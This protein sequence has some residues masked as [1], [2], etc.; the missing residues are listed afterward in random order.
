M[1]RIGFFLKVWLWDFAEAWFVSLPWRR[2]AGGL[3]FLLV[4]GF[5]LASTLVIGSGEKGLRGY[6]LRSQ[7][8]EALASD[9]WETAR[10]VLNRQLQNSPEDRDAK[11]QMARVLEA[12]GEREPAEHIMRSLTFV[13][14]PADERS[15]KPNGAPEEFDD[16]REWRRFGGADPRAARWMVQHVYRPQP[17]DEM[18]QVDRRDFLGLLKWMYESSP[19]DVPLRRLYAEKLLEARM[20]REALPVLVTLIQEGPGIGL[21]AATIARFL[22]DQRGAA[23]YAEQSLQQFAA[24]IPQEPTN[25]SLAVALARCQVFLGR[26]SA[27]VHTIQAAIKRSEQDEDRRLLGQILAEALVTWADAL[28]GKADSAPEER[29]QILEM[30][31]IAL[32]HAPHNERVLQVV[33]DQ[34]LTTAAADDRK[35]DS[36][37]TALTRGTS[38]GISHFIHGTAAVMR[39]EPEVAKIHLEV[40]ARTFPVSDAILNNLAWVLAQQQDADLSQALQ[41]SETSIAQASPPTAYHL[42]TRG[43]ILF[44]M[45]RYVEAIPDLEAGLAVPELAAGA[46]RSLAECYRK[47]GTLELSEQH[48][49]AAEAGTPGK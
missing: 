1:H 10:L 2:L 41:I 32:Q 40:A 11:V 36:L 13:G 21:R 37:R 42:E 44:R 26:H 46:H 12:M 9:D 7:I 45:G 17:W 20:Y 47:T 6:L 38:P 15:A 48:R 3:P 23:F 49:L 29:V 31:Q 27:A 28:E 16:S 18:S 19:D 30:L 33:A 35:L 5:L 8:T 34:V 22:G 25:P 39:G 14:A 4:C 24:L 43:Q